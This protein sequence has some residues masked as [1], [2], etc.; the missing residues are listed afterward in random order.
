MERN[1]MESVYKKYRN[2]VYRAA[3][4]CCKDHIQ[5]EDVTSDV[6]YRYFTCKKPPEGD[7]HIKAWLI[8]TAINCCK[9]I[10]KSFRYK[11]VVSLDETQLVYET[12]EE[13]EVY[14]A[15]ISLEA[16]YRIVIHLY[17]YEGYT[18]AEIS[19]MIHKSDS[20]V[21]SRLSRARKL[22]KK[23]LGKEFHI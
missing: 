5:A 20:A 22:L 9:D 15:V 23:S 7:E 19:D 10:F 12:P 3:F 13:S 14:H 11:N 8:R 17:Y 2:T 4:S 18:T 21:R 6:F 1:D 16:K